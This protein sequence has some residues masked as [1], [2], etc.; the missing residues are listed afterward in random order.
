MKKCLGVCCGE[1]AYQTHNERL[2]KAL[3]GYHQK[4]WPWSG[5]VL[6]E[7]RGV[8]DGYQQQFHLIDQW[9]YLKSIDS[10][11][12][13]MDNG[14]VLDKG[15]NK[16]A[17]SNLSKDLPAIDRTDQFD[18]DIY[19]IL[20]RFLLDPEKLKINHIRVHRLSSLKVDSMG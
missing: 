15:V 9:I 18:L 8:E 6:V 2:E 11:E 10:E 7:E 17:G 19:F 16:A 20:V 4:V 12:Q 1:E 5:A 14:Y 13:L 3:Q